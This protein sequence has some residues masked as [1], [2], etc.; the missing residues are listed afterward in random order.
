MRVESRAVNAGRETASDGVWVRISEEQVKK[1]T[2][3]IG[4]KATLTVSLND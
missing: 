3:N 4:D 1:C 2:R